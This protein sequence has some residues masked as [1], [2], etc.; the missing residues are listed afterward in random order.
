MS[1]E[2]AIGLFEENRQAF[3]KDL[4]AFLRFES[5]SAQSSHAGDVADCAAWIRDQL[6]AAGLQARVIPT[7][8]HPI[9]FADS[10][11]LPNDQTGPTLLLYGHYDVQPPG[12]LTLWD[13]PPFEPTV[14]NEALYAR[15]SA[16]DKGQLMTHF[17]ALRCWRETGDP[18]PVRVKCII[19][20]EEEIGSPHLPDFVRQ[21]ADLLACDDVVLSDTSKFD[22]D[23]PAM[24]YASRGLVYKEITVA[25]PNHDLHSGQYGGAVANPANT[26]ISIIASLHD[27]AGRVTIPG[28][29]DEVEPLTEQERAWM[30]EHG[31]SDD[32]LLAATGSPAAGEAGFSTAERCM[33]RPTLDVNGLSG[34]YTGEGAATVIPTHASAK[35]SMRLVAHQ[36]PDKISAAF[37]QA[38]QQTCPAGVRLSI[39]DH[40][41]CKAYIGPTDSPGMR[42][43]ARVLEASFGKP[44]VLTRKGGSLPILPLFK[45]CLGAD[46]LM[47]GFAVPDCNLHSPNEFFHLR[48]FDNGTRCILRFLGE[49][50]KQ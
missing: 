15:G 1:V 37:D 3:L 38:V 8:G 34:G 48:D 5:I 23:T 11:P 41:H 31:L 46:S 30:A 27:E 7:A 29:Y 2:N 4:D 14:R 47:L 6:A 39:V 44:P 25:G 28:F 43:A 33:A 22:T 24:A 9:V 40:H 26:L 13:S 49:M 12:D 16:D 50:G 17:A 21:H 36:D 20:G 42:V 45:E 10:G 32:A 18:L 19:E 35:V